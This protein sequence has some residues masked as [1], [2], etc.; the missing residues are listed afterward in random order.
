VPS[1]DHL[2]EALVRLRSRLWTITA[3]AFVLTFGLVL[4][5]AAC[6]GVSEDGGPEDPD[7]AGDVAG[8]VADDDSPAPAGPHG[9]LQL[10]GWERT[11]RGGLTVALRAIEVDDDGHVI[12]EIEAVS[13]RRDVRLNDFST[14]LVTDTDEVLPLAPPDE[15]EHLT[16]PQDQRMLARL[17]FVGP[18]GEDVTRVTLAINAINQRVRDQDDDNAAGVR[19]P[20]LAIRDVPLPGVGLD[21]DAVGDATVRED[22]TASAVVEPGVTQTHEG[23]TVVTVTRIEINASQ[24]LIEVEVVNP[25]DHDVRLRSMPPF[26][27]DDLGGRWVAENIE[28]DERS[29]RFF[30]VPAGGEAT[31]TLAFP[32]PIRQEASSLALTIGRPA[33]DSPRIP[34]F[35]FE[36][37]PIPGREGEAADR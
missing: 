36:G 5:L 21:T 12:L 22:L 37:L 10:T 13:A 1:P 2:L 7:V 27:E 14:Y 29:D 8:D 33:T 28:S 32:A 31:A 15:D 9:R 16:V 19:G 23:G 17:A 26:L 35:H 30:D 34:G 3:P 25:T 24:V 20:A 4:G 6:T 18:I 11:H